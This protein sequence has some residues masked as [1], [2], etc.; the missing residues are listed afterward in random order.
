MSNNKVAEN[1]YLSR[2][3]MY[4]YLAYKSK[5][6]EIDNNAFSL[7]DLEESNHEPLDLMRMSPKFHPPPHFVSV[8]RSRLPCIIGLRFF[9]MTRSKISTIKIIK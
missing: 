6:I 8:C 4:V 7:R 3:C 2:K 5:A 9:V 1:I